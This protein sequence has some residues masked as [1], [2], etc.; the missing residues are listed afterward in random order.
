[1]QN[2]GALP[3]GEQLRRTREIASLAS[4]VLHCKIMGARVGERSP[5]ASTRSRTRNWRDQ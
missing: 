3:H 2:E 4:V 5:V 1:M